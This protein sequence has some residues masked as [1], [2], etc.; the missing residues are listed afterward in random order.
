MITF[1]V[2]INRKN[3]CTRWTVNSLIFQNISSTFYGYLQSKILKRNQKTL[4]LKTV[5]FYKMFEKLTL[6]I[7]FKLVHKTEVC[8]NKIVQK[9]QTSTDHHNHIINLK[10]QQLLK[11]HLI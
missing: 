9:G 3:P 10:I 7:F 5:H 8:L 11:V 2:Y 6:T 4:K 1:Y